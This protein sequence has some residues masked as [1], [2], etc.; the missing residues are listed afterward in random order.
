MPRVFVSHSANDKYFVELLVECLKY[1]HI[2]VWYDSDKIKAGKKYKDEIKEGIA[3]SDYLIVVVSQH[4]LNSTWVT[5]ELSVFH[6][7]KPDSTIIPIFLEPVALAEVFDGL[8]DVQGIHFYKDMLSGFQTLMAVFGKA[9][10]PPIERREQNDRRKTDR[11]GSS[12]IQRMRF[13]LWKCF[14]SASGKDRFDEYDLSAQ[15]RIEV[16][17]TLRPELD[18]YIYKRADGTETELPIGELDHLTHQVWGTLTNRDYVTAI[19]VI[20]AITEAIFSAYDVKAIDK[21]IESSPVLT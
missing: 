11:R 19:M 3:N 20:E 7:T 2:E 17:E 21:R 9:F 5:R 4:V 16:L 15:N 1:H 13:G 6:A 10:L 12:V 8:E 18:R 14:Q